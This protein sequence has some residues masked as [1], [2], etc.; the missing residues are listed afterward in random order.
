MRDEPHPT[1]RTVVRSIAPLTL[2]A[3]LPSAAA[4][5]DDRPDRTHCPIDPPVP[6]AVANRPDTYVA[7]VDRIVDGRHVVIL[8]EADGAVVDQLVVPATELPC[9]EERDRLVVARDDRDVEW[10][11]RLCDT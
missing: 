10:V 5:A 7:T 6:A 4:A 9:V 11:R 3:A 1:R 2:A 8:L